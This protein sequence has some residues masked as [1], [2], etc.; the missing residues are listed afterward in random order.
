MRCD[1]DSLEHEFLVGTVIVRTRT[2]YYIRGRIFILHVLDTA[3]YSVLL[4]RCPGPDYGC[5]AYVSVKSLFA[6]IFI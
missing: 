3:Y 5:I 1:I 2:R 6:N 4:S